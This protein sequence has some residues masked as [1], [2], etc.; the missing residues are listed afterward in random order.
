MTDQQF[1]LAAKAMAKE[2]S[3]TVA[4]SAM[5]PDDASNLAGAALG[6][7]LAQQLGVFGAANRLRDLADVMEAQALKEG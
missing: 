5:S 7:I 6:E 2:Y 3:D 1:S 4:R